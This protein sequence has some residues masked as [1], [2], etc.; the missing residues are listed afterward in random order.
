MRGLAALIVVVFHARDSLWTGISNLWKQYGWD[1]GVNVWLGYLTL[2]FS[3]GDVAVTLFFVLSGYCIHRSGAELIAKHGT[4]SSPSWS[5]YVWR[6]F[7][8]IYPTYVA[9][10]II[11]GIVDVNA[12]PRLPQLT[13]LDVSMRTLFGNLLTLQ[14]TIVRQFGSN[15]VFWSLAIEIH[16]YFVYPILFI[17]SKRFGPLRIICVTLPIPIFLALIEWACFRNEVTI[18]TGK[19]YFFRFLSLWM[20]GF[21]AAEVQV[22]RLRNFVAPAWIGWLAFTGGMILRVLHR[23]DTYATFVLADLLLGVAFFYLIL[24]STS[25]SSNSS[26]GRPL[27]VAACLGTFSYSLYAV[28]RPVL[29]AFKAAVDPAGANRASLWF[30]FVGIVLAI[31]GGA[32]FYQVVERPALWISKRLNFR[33]SSSP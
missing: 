27:R 16:I 33:G 31:A 20:L 8:R 6:R 14:N 13:D 29:L 23:S 12:I 11:T 3:Y 17:G 9:A 15:S 28:H 21:L 24:H 18:M 32:V 26:L 30:L 22:G 5:D 25:W 2:P 4:E 1:G 19:L 10:L 7:W